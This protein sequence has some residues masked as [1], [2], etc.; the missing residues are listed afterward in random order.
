MDF[1]KIYKRGLGVSFL[2]LIVVIGVLFFPNLNKN[3]VSDGNSI[4]TSAPEDNYEPNN[5]PTTPYDITS[6]EGNWLSFLN[7]TGTQWDD[8]WYM[9]NI[10]PGKEHLSV[11]LTFNHSEGDIDLELYDINGSVPLTGSYDVIDNEYIDTAVPSPGL[12]LLRVYLDNMGNIYDLWWNTS[13]PTDD[14]Y[15]E[16]DDWTMA[17][18]ISGN[19]NA[20]HLGIQA[21]DDWYMT[22][23]DPGE[24]RL[25]VD[26]YHT[27]SEGDIDFE[28]YYYDGM[29][30]NW[31]A[32]TNDTCIDTNVPWSG[33]YYIHVYGEN[34]GN[35]YDLRWE[36]LIP[37]ISDDWM[38]ENDDFWSSKWIDPNY[39]SGLRIVFFDEDWFHLK[40]Y[41]GDIIDVSIFFNHMEGDLDLELYDPSNSLRIG[42]YSVDNNEFISY[43]ADVSGD[44]RIRVYH[45]NGDSEVWYDLDIWLN[46][47]GPGDDWMEEN[48]GYWSSWWVNP[49]WYPGLKL[50]KDDEDWFHTYLDS[51]DIIDISIFFKNEVGNLELELYDPYESHRMGSYSNTN[52]EFITFKADVSGD[53]RI[54]VYHK[55]G[56]SEVRYDLSIWLKDDFYEFNDEPNMI[57]DYKDH[58]SLLIE[59][60]QTWLS[61]HLGLA[62]QGNNDWYIIDITPGFERLI[63]EL[64]FNHSLG[65]I[66]VDIYDQN[67]LWITGNNS[68]TDDEYI[69]Y[70]LP[71]P[72]FYAILVYGYDWGNEYDMW[73]DDL[74]TDLRSDDNYELNNNPSS[75]YD[76]SYS[77]EISLWELNGLAL[78]YDEDWY[79]IYVDG[80]NLELV[81]WVFYDSA[82]GLM[83]FEVYDWNLNKIATNFTLTDNDHIIQE[84]SNGTYYI[85][86]FGDNS[87]NVY[88]LWWATREPEE[89][90]MIPG[91]DLLILIAS[92]IGISMVGIKV[93][94]SKLRHK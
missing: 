14:L 69:D 12:Y 19:E 1:K 24:M 10:V 29:T 61:D 70:M 51:G 21:D 78:Q 77:P 91:Y 17:Y 42:S 2:L 79:E 31:I 94:R 32:W 39:H 35:T 72:G 80:S 65:D 3:P 11:V 13:M 63:L 45:V 38:E 58:P 36:D 71:H 23:V 92:I 41:P 50:V 59:Y 55:F 83:G 60:E 33:W 85:R 86:V 6:N 67:G 47:G 56:D 57:K 48:D 89:I 28:I 26:V 4:F 74:R 93:K 53:W 46:A 34:A 44:W 84:V 87:G 76:I 49:N 64:K 40:L 88:N 68:N 54:R 25:H 22:W 52:S 15:E 81:V 30:L 18:D 62:V 82:E 73:W 66:G 90:G 43:T 37:S 7:G 27:H 5:S 20:S 75:A 8:D 9:I 16:N